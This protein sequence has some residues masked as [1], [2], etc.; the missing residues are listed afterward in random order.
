MDLARQDFKS[1]LV[2]MHLQG[3]SLEERAMSLC[4]DTANHFKKMSPEALDRLKR[5]WNCPAVV[6]VTFISRTW[7]M[8]KFA[9]LEE[10]IESI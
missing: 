3:R 4:Q 5:N 7:V 9:Q 2:D 10:S 8:C 1:I 6:C